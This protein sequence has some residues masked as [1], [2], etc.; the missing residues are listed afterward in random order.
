MRMLVVEDDA[1]VAALV[2]AY[3]ESAGWEV[4]TAGR[5]EQGLAAFGRM[6]P[7]V[8]V[9]DVM[10]PDGSGLDLLSAIRARSDAY[11][12]LLTA[13]GAEADRITGLHRGA[14]DYVVKPFSPGELMARCQALLRRPRGDVQAGAHAGAQVL[15]FGDLLIDPA[16]YRV[17]LAGE[18]VAL[19][20]L[21]MS[22]L[23]VLAR[24]PG[25][26]F[27]RSQL[28]EALWSTAYEGYDR[29]IDVHVGHLRRKLRDEADAP[30]FI[31]T[32]R[33]VGYRFRPA[34]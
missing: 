18:P 22:L 9:L 29:V 5:V 25:R 10:L 15:R 23:L 13:R 6:S 31:E 17:E 1:E 3:A 34:P 19:T 21:E 7:D 33:G 8:V 27:T 12:V 14:D 16:Q 2:A 30:R 28:V 11:V 26:V 24:Q 20:A 4:E 32:V